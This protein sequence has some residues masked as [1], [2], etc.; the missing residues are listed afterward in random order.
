LVP[1]QIA[2]GTYKQNAEQTQEF[3]L[4]ARVSEKLLELETLTAQASLGEK[5]DRQKDDALQ[6]RATKCIFL[7]H[8][9]SG[10]I[11]SLLA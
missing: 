2:F 10:V 7:Q 11:F 6:I 5:T 3:R 9:P 8:T 4:L 1:R